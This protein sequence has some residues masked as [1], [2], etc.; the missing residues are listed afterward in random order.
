MN[1]TD[2]AWCAGFFDGEGCV[3]YNR[4]RPSSKGTVSPSLMAT[5]S[6]VSENV[7]VLEF[8]Q[9]T[10]GLGK[11]LGPYTMPNG[12]PQH[13]LWFGTDEVEPLFEMLRPYLKTRK[14]TDFI[15]AIYSYRNH[16]NEM[17]NEDDDRMFRAAERQRAKSGRK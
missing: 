13:R 2:I 11:V 16:S 15:Q 17:N 5:I 10:V 12:K 3:R 4:S 8:F 1:H 7:E 9:R 14:T 6:Q